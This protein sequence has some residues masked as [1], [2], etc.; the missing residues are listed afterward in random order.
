MLS[1]GDGLSSALRIPTKI[2]LTKTLSVSSA[3]N[4]NNSFLNS[5]SS[6]MTDITEKPQTALDY[7]LTPPPIIIDNKK[8]QNTTKGY[9]SKNFI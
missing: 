6:S 1:N 8:E 3:Q 5:T 9:F 7:P 4:E 2:Q